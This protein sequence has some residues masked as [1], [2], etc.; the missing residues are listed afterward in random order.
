MSRLPP[1]A[2]RAAGTQ[3]TIDRFLGKPF[4]LSWN[5]CCRM[6]AMHLRRL[7][8]K[9]QLPK[10]GSYKT[11]LAARRALA[12]AGVANLAEALDRLGLERIAPASV[13]VGDII[14]LPSEDGFSALAVVVGGGKALGFHQ[15][16]AGATIMKPSQFVAAWRAL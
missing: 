4:R 15:E 3:A 10:A 14:E 6:T 16:A 7:G 1:M 2:R 12:A 9:V 13:I 11:P 5:D 8:H